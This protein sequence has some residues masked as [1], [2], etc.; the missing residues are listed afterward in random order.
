MKLKYLR[1]PL[2]TLSSAKAVLAARLSMLSFSY[3]GRRKFR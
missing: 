1:D 3:H 2:R